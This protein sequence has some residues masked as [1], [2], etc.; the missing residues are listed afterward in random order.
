M[1][2]PK[3]ARLPAPI[4]T[5]SV[6]KKPVAHLLVYALERRLTG[7]FELDDDGREQMRI[8]VFQGQVARVSTTE[9]LAY[10]GH[11]LYE[12]GVIDG[13]ALGDSLVEVAATKRL[14]GQVLVTCGMITPDQLS[15]ALRRQRTR[16]LDHAFRLSSRTTFAFF[17]GVDL[18]GARPG[19][20]EPIDPLPAIWRGIRTNP[21]WEHVRSTM[22]TIGGRALRVTGTVD[23]LGLD[24]KERIAAE[25]LA[26]APATVM[27]L[28][29]GAK[30]DVPAAEVLAYFLV[31]AGLAELTEPTP[32]RRG[33][34]PLPPD[35][36]GHSLGTSLKSGEHARSKISFS[37]RATLPDASPLRIPSPAAP[38]LG[39]IAL[40]TPPRSTRSLDSPTPYRAT[41]PGKV[42]ESSTRVPVAD[43]RAERRG[44]AKRELTAAE[45]ALSEAE[46][47]LLLG[48]RARARG[49][50]RTALAMAPGMPPALALLAH[51]EA[52][53]LGEG[54][55]AYLADLLRVM[56]A[57]I[58]K[59]AKC[60]R[61][62]FYRA[63]V[64]NRLGDYEGGLSDLRI[65]VENDPEDADALHELGVCERRAS[66]ER[67]RK[68]PR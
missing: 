45:K 32:R 57:A 16:K 31:I 37:M 60:R 58:V 59:D 20:V 28:A 23:R 44:E 56:D 5:G 47:H 54:Q 18:V 22:E 19:D 26:D 65:A 1:L 43:G 41:L 68:D 3:P 48:D 6:A 62:H 25:S 55:E 13:A 8:V 61:G 66:R 11:V 21:A 38:L 29:A 24:A 34:P 42:C 53:A 17:A 49:F 64:R 10:L 40:T 35:S 46:I 30:L 2:Q 50:V 4:A 33:P 9:P 14:H 12:L 39:R 15:T 27:E 63:E 67:I 36:Q 52:Q 7:T 51:L